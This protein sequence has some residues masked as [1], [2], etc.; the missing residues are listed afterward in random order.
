MKLFIALSLTV[1]GLAFTEQGYIT[2]DTDRT[3]LAIYLDS[4]LIGV[5]P[6]DQHTV[7]PGEHTVSLFHPDTIEDAYWQMRQQGFPTMVTKLPGLR[8]YDVGTK[9]VVINPN[10]TVKVYLSYTRAERAPSQTCCLMGGCVTGVVGG[11]IVLGFVL[12]LLLNR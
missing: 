6:I 11:S 10:E 5:S 2:V 8:R 4:E 7:S 1:C 3:G 9:R 12:A